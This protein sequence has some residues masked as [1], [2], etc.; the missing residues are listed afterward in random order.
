MREDLVHDLAP[1]LAS[2]RE[3]PHAIIFAD[4]QPETGSFISLAT[5]WHPEHRHCFEVVGHG[6][7]RGIR[8]SLIAPGAIAG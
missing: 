5:T 3:R 2:T 4:P 7:L 6:T 1:L 8:C